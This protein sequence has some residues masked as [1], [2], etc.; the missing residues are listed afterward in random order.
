MKYL[1]ILGL[2]VSIRGLAPV[3]VRSLPPRQLCCMMCGSVSPPRTPLPAG[4]EQKEAASGNKTL[5]CQR[6]WRPGHGDRP[7]LALE[8]IPRWLGDRRGTEWVVSCATAPA[9]FMNENPAR[10][11]REGRRKSEL[12]ITAIVPSPLHRPAGMGGLEITQ[13]CVGAGGGGERTGKASWASAQRFLGSPPDRS[14][15][16]RG[17]GMLAELRGSQLCEGRSTSSPAHGD[18]LCLG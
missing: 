8:P 10:A 11:G 1:E 14:G 3:S 15:L 18:T 5:S 9:L 6:R 17:W 4:L 7:W 13:P 16:L 12:L 2:E